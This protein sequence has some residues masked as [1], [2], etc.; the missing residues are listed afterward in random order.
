MRTH[1]FSLL[2]FLLLSLLFNACGKPEHKREWKIAFDP[3]W[4]PLDLMG[5]E[6]QLQG[7]TTDLLHEWG[8]VEKL[9]ILMVQ[10]NWDTLISNLQKKESDAILS[11]LQ[12]YLFYEKQFDFSEPFLLTGPILVVPAESNSKSLEEFSG[13]EIAVISGSQADLSIEKYPGIIIRYYEAI[14]DAFN[15]ILTGQVDGAV[16]GVLPAAAYCQD[17]YQGKL[18]VVGHPLTAQGL[19]LITLYN[20]AP[21][22]IESFNTMLKELKKSGKYAK[23]ARKWKFPEE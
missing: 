2:F 9:K 1:R 18:K 4:Y 5:R 6:K 11:S 22:L 13:K 15:A 10:D 23:I 20:E 12:P 3:S 19:R 14:P 16:V 7:F 8:K 17:L 21:L